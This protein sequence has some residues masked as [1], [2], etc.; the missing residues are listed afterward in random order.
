MPLYLE[1]LDQ[2]RS[3]CDRL[4]EAGFCAKHATE[5]EGEEDVRA[6]VAAGPNVAAVSGDGGIAPHH[7]GERSRW[8]SP[9]SAKCK[10][11]KQVRIDTILSQSSSACTA[12][13]DSGMD[14]CADMSR[15]VTPILESEAC[16]T[17]PGSEA[18]SSWPFGSSQM[19]EE[20]HKSS[21]SV[22][23]FHDGDA[24][25]DMQ[26][27][28]MLKKLEDKKGAFAKTRAMSCCGLSAENAEENLAWMKRSRLPFR[29]G[30]LGKAVGSKYFHSLISTLIVA[31]VIFI[32]VESDLAL[33][34]SFDFARNNRGVAPSMGS[35]FRQFDAFFTWAFATELCL[36]ML[37]EELSF[38]FGPNWRWNVFDSCL[39]ATSVMESFLDGR[40][41][42]ATFARVLRVLRMSRALRI[43]RMFKAFRELRM[44]LD[45]IFHILLPLAWSV[46]LLSI[47]IV[48]FGLI[49]INAVNAY[50]MSDDYDDSV[51]DQLVIYFSSAPTTFVSLFKTLTNGES[52]GN[53]MKPLQS[54]SDVYAVVFILFVLFLQLGVLNIITSVFVGNATLLAQMDLDMIQLAEAD[55]HQ[56]TMEKLDEVF[57]VLDKDGSGNISL[58]EFETWTRIEKVRAFFERVLGLEAWKVGRFF[59]MLDSNGDDMIDKKEFVVGCMR[60]KGGAKNMDQEVLTHLTKVIKSDIKVVKGRLD[61]LA[62]KINSE[63]VTTPVS[64]PSR[65][66]PET[67][68][69]TISSSAFSRMTT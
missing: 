15:G 32:I 48:L 49:F 21:R 58:T 64:T 63:L 28:M 38:V 26:Y 23:I 30:L 42:D 4:A 7:F 45:S 1:L 55:Q 19:K 43:I 59:R 44:L 12:V 52:W 16:T 20:M 25:V 34:L 53:I 33:R 67:P 10:P 3:E 50:L 6:H 18:A 13:P 35:K 46:L 56:Y 47:V 54:L 17:V 9:W 14:A 24:D 41:I 62:S 61:I 51:G 68:G 37:V 22:N 11:Q 36:R 66:L 8:R 5:G 69:H 60:L 2:L 27:T 65:R 29:N 31:N 39:V 57:S 40:G